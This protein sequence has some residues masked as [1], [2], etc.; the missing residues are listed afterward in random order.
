MKSGHF[1]RH[2]LTAP[3]VAGIDFE[4]KTVDIDGQ[5]VKLQ[6]P[7]NYPVLTTFRSFSVHLLLQ[8]WETAGNHRFKS[9]T[10]GYYRGAHAVLILYD[11]SDTVSAIHP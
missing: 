6:V 7:L 11:I 1:D 2:L 9:I 8:I 3:S 4:I 5:R 10:A